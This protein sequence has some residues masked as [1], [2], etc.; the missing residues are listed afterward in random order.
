MAAGNRTRYDAFYVQDQWTRSRLTLQGALRYEHAWS[1]FPEGQNGLLADSVFGGPARTLPRREGC[2][3]LQRHHAAHGRGLRRVRQRQDGDQGEPVEVLAVAANDGVY[4]G[5]NPASTFAQTAN[6]AWTDANGNFTP[7]CDLLNPLAQDNRATGGDFCGAL[8]NQNFF[9]FRQTTRLWARPRPSI[10]A[11]LERLGRASLR[12]AVR[13][14]G[15]AAA[16]AARVGRVRLQ[17]PL[18]GQLHR[19]RQPRGRRRRTSTP[20]RSRRRRDPRPAERRADDLATR[21]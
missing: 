15:A 10:P 21:C 1:F 5:T 12:L 17:P 3:R 6:R 20:T 9:A 14:V 18:V 4:I 16:A 2:H 8:D 13:R 7:D 11:L 19:H